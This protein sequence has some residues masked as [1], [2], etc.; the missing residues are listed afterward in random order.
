MTAS[1]GDWESNPGLYT[2]DEW[3]CLETTPRAAVGFVLDPYSSAGT[4]R[5]YPR[6][7]VFKAYEA[8]SAQF[9]VSIVADRA[10]IKINSVTEVSA[11]VAFP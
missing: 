10:S 9:R 8:T 1:V 2:F 3:R 11:L 6:D 4:D 7:S 5:R